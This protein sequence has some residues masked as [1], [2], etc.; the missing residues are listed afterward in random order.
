M[1]K[2]KPV[3]ETNLTPKLALTFLQ[4]LIII[5]IYFIAVSFKSDIV[6]FIFAVLGIFFHPIIPNWTSHGPIN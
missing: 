4:I 1:P 2:R 3:L 5:I 6:N